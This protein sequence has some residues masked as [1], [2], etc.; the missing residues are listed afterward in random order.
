MGEL[1]VIISGSFAVQF[2]ERMTWPSSD[3]DLYVKDGEELMAPHAYLL[4]SEG[5]TLQSETDT[6]DL[7]YA[8]HNLVTVRDSERSWR[9]LTNI[10]RTFLRYASTQDL[11]QVV[12]RTSRPRSTL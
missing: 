5:Y 1:N 4:G 12:S 6:E 10:W 9:L 3:L 11:F 2:F 8:M 7:P